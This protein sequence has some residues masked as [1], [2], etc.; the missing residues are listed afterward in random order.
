[1]SVFATPADQDMDASAELPARLTKPVK[2]DPDLISNLDTLGAEDAEMR[3][4]HVEQ[5][6]SF[7][8]EESLPDDVKQ[9]ILDARCTLVYG[10]GAPSWTV[11]HHASYVYEDGT[12]EAVPEYDDLFPYWDK[13]QLYDHQYAG[14][15]EETS[16]AIPR[17]W[18]ATAVAT[19][20]T[21]FI[22]IRS[23]AILSW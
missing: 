18:S 5:W 23:L 19:T 6:A 14:E 2:Y 10:P 15:N 3:A 16:S 13:G 21:C 12:E 20:S 7:A 17:G 4:Q 9:Q 22:W 8:Y 11:N 1:M